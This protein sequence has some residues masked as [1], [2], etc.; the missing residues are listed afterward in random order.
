MLKFQ[1]TI[2]YEDVFC[3]SASIIVLKVLCSR[4]HKHFFEWKTASCNR[5]MSTRMRSTENLKRCHR[6]QGEVSILDANFLKKKFETPYHKLR[7]TQTLCIVVC[8]DKWVPFIYI[9][10]FESIGAR[11]SHHSKLI[12][13]LSIQAPPPSLSSTHFFYSIHP[14]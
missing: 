10:A 9:V 13:P 14:S 7:S 11:H 1:Q 5:N 6:V 2:F 3:C 4:H 8:R 12:L